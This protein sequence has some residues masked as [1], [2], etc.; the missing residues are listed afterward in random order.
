MRQLTFFGIVTFWLLCFSINLN[1]KAGD[2]LIPVGMTSRIACN[3][4]RMVVAHVVA[5]PPALSVRSPLSVLSVEPADLVEGPS[6]D[7]DFQI[8]VRHGVV[9][10]KDALTTEVA[11]IFM[12]SS[13]RI[14]CYADFDS[15]VLF[16]KLENGQ[17]IEYA[18]KCR[19]VSSAEGG[20]VLWEGVV[21]YKGSRYSVVVVRR[22]AE[23]KGPLNLLSVMRKSQQMINVVRPDANGFFKFKDLTFIPIPLASNINGVFVIPAAGSNRDPELEIE[24]SGQFCFNSYLVVAPSLGSFRQYSF[25]GGCE[26]CVRAGVCVVSDLNKFKLGVATKQRSLVMRLPAFMPNDKGH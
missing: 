9:Q 1:A 26:V 25:E 18:S 4:G 2:E 14:P 5:G 15:T 7:F 21:D 11:Q 12:E 19:G 22:S 24:S 10:A 3:N 6:A 23:T 13:E 16:K 17:S 20:D 8:D